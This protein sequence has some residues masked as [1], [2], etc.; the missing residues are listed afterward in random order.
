MDFEQLRIKW[1]HCHRGS[2]FTCKCFAV[3]AIR[4]S[5]EM[6]PMSQQQWTA[7]DNYIS[8]MLVGSDPVLDAALAASAEA[9]L[10]QIQVTPNQGKLLYLIAKVQSARSILEIGTLGGYSTIWLAR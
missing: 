7:V 1:Q 4:T 2:N 3:P 8:D 9:G 10:P 5:L 6:P